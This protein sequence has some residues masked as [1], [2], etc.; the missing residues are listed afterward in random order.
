MTGLG[1]NTFTDKDTNLMWQDNSEVTNNHKNWHGAITYCN[2]LTFGGYS[3]WR[4]PDKKE[5][6]SITDVT[7]YDLA[8]K[9]EFQNVSTY[10]WSSST[11]ANNS[12]GAWLV[13]FS[14]GQSGNNNKNLSY[15]LVRCV[16]DSN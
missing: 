14:K 10:Y 11:R 3:D 8:I 2:N 9:S 16:R 12:G 13:E 7:R 1:A 5:L 6:F 4:L 15:N